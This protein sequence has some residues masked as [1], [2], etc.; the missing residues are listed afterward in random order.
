ML[1]KK[2]FTLVEVLVAAFITI[3]VLIGVY[4]LFIGG[5][6]TADKGQWINGQVEQLRNALNR[7][8]KE[9]ETSTYPTTL[10]KNKIYD[11]CDNP[12]L[13][14]AEKYY[15]RVL[16]KD[17]PIKIPESGELKIMEWYVCVAEKPE[18]KSSSEDE[19]D[20]LLTKN[21]LFLEFKNKLPSA[22]TGNLVLKSE[23]FKYSTNPSSGYAKSGKLN[24]S[25]KNK[26]NKILVEDVEWVEF[27][28]LFPSNKNNRKKHLDFP[29]IS[30]K[31]HTLYPKDV[32]VFK[33]NFVTATPQVAVDLL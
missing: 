3:L 9:I 11:P 4:K 1:K 12:D 21:Q 22:N 29:A 10:F 14:V 5:S 2:G 6:R 27:S 32:N 15:M 17:T 24:L 23:T 8:S 33:E 28:G 7:L 20:G 26:I 18:Q 25:S 30:V 31:I 19:K 13:K 16:E